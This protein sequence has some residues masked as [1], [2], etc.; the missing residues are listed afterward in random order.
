MRALVLHVRIS[1]PGFRS[2]RAW[3]RWLA[4]HLV[5]NVPE[6]TSVCEFE[7]QDARCSTAKLAIC[8]KCSSHRER[9]LALN[10]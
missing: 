1:A 6:E 9:L 5:Q 7:C 2:V 4:D 8:L 3:G 10:D